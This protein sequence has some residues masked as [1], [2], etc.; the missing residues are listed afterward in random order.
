MNFITDRLILR[1]QWRIKRRFPSVPLNKLRITLCNEFSNIL[2]QVKKRK[3]FQSIVFFLFSYVIT[4]I[5][6][7]VLVKPTHFATS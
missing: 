7:F 4:I 3:T 1:R 6:T 2:F 5:S